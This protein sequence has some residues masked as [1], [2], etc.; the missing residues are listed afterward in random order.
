MP[1]YIYLFAAQLQF[2]PVD[3]R[4]LSYLIYFLTVKINYYKF[5]KY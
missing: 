1:C 3:L 5:N 4:R 2:Q